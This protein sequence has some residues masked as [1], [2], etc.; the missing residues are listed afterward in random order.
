MRTH[1]HAP[2][3]LTERLQLLPATV[4]ALKAELESRE[5][6]ARVLDVDVPESWPPELY[7]A[8]ATRWILNAMEA[9][10][11]IPT[12]WGMYYMTTGTNGARPALVGIVGYKGEPNE[13]G[14]VEIGYG[15][16]P[17]RRRAG[18]AT[19]ATRRLVE[20]AFEDPRVQGVVAHTL[21]EL[22]PSIGVL[23]KNGF[24]LTGEGNDPGEP[25]AI[26]YELSRVDWLNGRSARPSS[27]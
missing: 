1:D 12:P 17:E 25:T 2:P 11:G 3:L 23:E 27:R 19:E 18:F 22:L 14:N 9:A 10:G 5:G 13:W 7:D 16:V 26:R 21:P 8:D 24:R 15:V 20:R 6:L 4:D